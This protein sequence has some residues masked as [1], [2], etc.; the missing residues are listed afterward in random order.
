MLGRLGTTGNSRRQS[1][2]LLSKSEHCLTPLTNSLPFPHHPCY[3]H[4]VFS[5]HLA[6]LNASQQLELGKELASCGQSTSL[7]VTNNSWIILNRGTRKQI[8]HASCV[9]LD[10]LLI[11][12][13]AS[14]C[15]VLCYELVR[16]MNSKAEA[17][18]L[19]QTIFLPI[20]VLA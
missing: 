18:R 12:S 19:P 5:R 8:T 1:Y 16:M 4:K 2:K 7:L 10:Q 3:N 6:F 9:T 11:D 17:N 20:M 13:W 15:L 14:N